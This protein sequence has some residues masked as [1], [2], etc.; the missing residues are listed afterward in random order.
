MSFC[1]LKAIL[2]TSLFFLSLLW[3]FDLNLLP[4]L[5]HTFSTVIAIITSFFQVFLTHL[6]A[7]IHTQHI[8]YR[9]GRL[10]RSP[11]LKTLHFQLCFFICL[12]KCL[13][14][15]DSSLMPHVK[16]TFVRSAIVTLS[17][18]TLQAPGYL[19]HRID[20]KSTFCCA[21]IQG[22]CAYLNSLFFQMGCQ[23]GLMWGEENTKRG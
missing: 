21:N 4:I 8:H 23:F 2:Y 3:R 16:Q 13:E 14:Q 9:C 12:K 11:V 15:Q 6:Q 22:C 19:Q 1:F 17:P 18:L 20:D 5:I 7:C 10:M